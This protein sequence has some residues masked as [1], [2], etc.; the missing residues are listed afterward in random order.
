MLIVVPVHKSA[1]DMSS[2]CNLIGTH[3]ITCTAIHMPSIVAQAGE[4]RSRWGPQN[5][6]AQTLYLHLV[7]HG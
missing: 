3:I 7:G 4:L 2:Q 6:P 1:R 5:R